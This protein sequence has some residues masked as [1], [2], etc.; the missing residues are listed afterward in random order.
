MVYQQLMCSNAAFFMDTSSPQ[1][2]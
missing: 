1:S 2:T